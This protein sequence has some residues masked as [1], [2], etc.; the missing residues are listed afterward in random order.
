M[1]IEPELVHLDLRPVEERFDRLAVTLGE[2]FDKHKI[3]VTLNSEINENLVHLQNNVEQGEKDFRSS[4]SLDDEHRFEHLIVSEDQRATSFSSRHSFLGHRE[5]SG[6]Q[7]G[8]RCQHRHSDR[9]TVDDNDDDD[10]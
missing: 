4:I 6:S 9:T 3:S 1:R 7:H 5:T 8:S 2:A 10:E